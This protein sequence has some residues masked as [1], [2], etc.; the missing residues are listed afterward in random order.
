M[1]NPPVNITVAQEFE[2][3]IGELGLYLWDHDDSHQLVGDL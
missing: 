2:A 1:K 3:L